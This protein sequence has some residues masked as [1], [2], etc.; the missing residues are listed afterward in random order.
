MKNITVSDSRTGFMLVERKFRWPT[1]ANSSNLGSLTQSFFQF[2]REVDEG[3][4]ESVVF[5]GKEPHSSGKSSSGSGSSTSKQH[6][7]MKMVCSRNEFETISIYYDTTNY[8]VDPDEANS[9]LLAIGNQ[10]DR[11]C[12][13]LLSRLS[14]LIASFVDSVE[15]NTE[16]VEGVRSQFMFFGDHIDRIILTAFPPEPPRPPTPP[17]DSEICKSISTSRSRSSKSSKGSRGKSRGGS[18]KSMDIN[19]K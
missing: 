1:H 19:G 2:A 18:K 15:E 11:E 17:R 6:Q 5:E 14:G 16:E 8:V 12:G 4:I 13:D 9:L 3:L 10:F 7:T